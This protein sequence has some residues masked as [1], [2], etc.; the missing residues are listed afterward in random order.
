MLIPTSG[1][2]LA[3]LLSARVSYGR[4]LRFALPGSLLV[5]LVGVVGVI[6]AG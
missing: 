2:L 6:L 4:W 1:A 3:M 5:A